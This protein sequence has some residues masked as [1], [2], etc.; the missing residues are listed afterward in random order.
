MRRPGVLA[1]ALLALVATRSTASADDRL[2]TRFDGPTDAG[3]EL[4]RFDARA[5][6][7][8]DDWQR[9]CRLPCALRLRPARYL[10]ALNGGF[11]FFEKLLQK[12]TFLKITFNFGLRFMYQKSIFWAKMD[13]FWWIKDQF[14]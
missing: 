13:C 11:R 10:L 6:R 3:L 7:T 14:E 2:P 12:L 9:L 4:A 5:R 1:A 8:V